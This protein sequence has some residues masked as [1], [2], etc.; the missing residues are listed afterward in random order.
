MDF[1]ICSQAWRQKSLAWQ[2]NLTVGC[3]YIWCAFIP[4]SC[5]FFCFSR[6]IFFL[7]HPSLW[8]CHQM[9]SALSI[10]MS[11][12]KR[13]P[14]TSQPTP[15][16]KKWFL[17][18]K[19]NAFGLKW[20]RWSREPAP[21]SANPWLTWKHRLEVHSVKQWSSFGPPVSL[22]RGGAALALTNTRAAR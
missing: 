21:L 11:S 18:D 8:S 19:P 16:E 5:M 15:S 3:G 2:Y 14:L 17:L 10:F 9:S 20:F 7:S 12:A 4:S 13:Q 6:C 1:L 22:K